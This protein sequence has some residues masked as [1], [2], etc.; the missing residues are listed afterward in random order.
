MY[1]KAFRKTLDADERVIRGNG[2]AHG[3]REAE[4]PGRARLHFYL[5]ALRAAP[6]NLALLNG[7]HGVM[8]AG[9]TLIEGERSRRRTVL[10]ARAAPRSATARHG[11]S[12]VKPNRTAATSALQK[13]RGDCT[14]FLQFA[15]ALCPFTF[16]LN[17]ELDSAQRARYA[18]FSAVPE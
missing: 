5:R 12:A 4:P 17:R 15:G 10:R 9:V 8:D 16:F 7:A 2:L 11:E 1:P 18:P 13:T 14:C 6:A 3:E